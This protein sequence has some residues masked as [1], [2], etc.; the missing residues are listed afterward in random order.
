MHILGAPETYPLCKKQA[1]NIAFARFS[2]AV[3]ERTGSI[4]GSAMSLLKRAWNRLSKT[5]LMASGGLELAEI[6][7][8]KV[9]CV[10][11]F[12]SY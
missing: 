2:M 3:F 9:A 10:S 6:Q 1:L 11:K 8:S 12:K 4:L 5:Y 7:C